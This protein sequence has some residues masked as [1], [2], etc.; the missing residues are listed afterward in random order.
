M[1]LIK[2]TQLNGT[3]SKKRQRNYHSVILSLNATESD[4]DSACISAENEAK[5]NGLCIVVDLV[6]D[7]YNNQGTL[8]QYLH[9]RFQVKHAKYNC[10]GE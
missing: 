3:N 6:L 8:S 1:I 4:F 10:K 5:E 9:E 7:H 2:K